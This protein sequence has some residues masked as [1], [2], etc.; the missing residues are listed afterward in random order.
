M[1]KTRTLL[2][3]SVLSLGIL[4]AP[5]APTNALERVSYFA[6]QDVAYDIERIET[7]NDNITIHGYFQN[8]REDV[9]N[10]IESM[11]IALLDANGV[12]YAMT[13]KEHESF[14]SVVLFPGDKRVPFSI[15]LPLKNS[16]RYDF[17]HYQGAIQLKYTT[18]KFGYHVSEVVESDGVFRI[19]GH[20]FN[21]TGLKALNEGDLIVA[22][23]D[24]TGRQMTKRLP[25]NRL[26]FEK[27]TEV[28]YAFSLRTTGA[29]VNKIVGFTADF[30]K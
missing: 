22:Y 25:F 4:F 23:E 18:V 27:Q 6:K 8:E 11:N 30:R 14:S 1:M 13:V 7:K 20:F 19:K 16:E 15:T 29:K 24:A 5:T 9:V 10:A 28:P 3:C 21:Y 26:M 12:R 17:S 2:T